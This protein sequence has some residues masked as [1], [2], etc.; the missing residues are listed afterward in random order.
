LFVDFDCALLD[1]LLVFELFVHVLEDLLLVFVAE[2][3]E[4]ESFLFLLVLDLQRLDGTVVL[5]DLGIQLVDFTDNV[6]EFDSIFQ[7][8]YLLHQF[9][10]VVSEFLDLIVF[11]AYL[12]RVFDYLT[13]DF[14][15]FVFLIGY[16]VFEFV[17]CFCEN[18][19]FDHFFEDTRFDLGFLIFQVTTDDRS[20][21]FQ[22]Y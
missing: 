16:F 10:F 1:L 18:F 5:L 20:V 11:V 3:A 17:N 12:I 2:L 14:F 6:F 4:L 7:L 22:F 13:V 15:K 8:I 21:F 9:V 19:Y